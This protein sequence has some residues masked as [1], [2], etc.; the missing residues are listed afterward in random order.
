MWERPAGRT[1][2]SAPAASGGLVCGCGV[3]RKR[4]RLCHS[5]GSGSAASLSEYDGGS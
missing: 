3:V 1:D 5:R 4:G 2:R